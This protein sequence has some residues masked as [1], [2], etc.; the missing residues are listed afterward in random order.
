VKLPIRDTAAVFEAFPELRQSLLAHFDQCPLATRFDLEG[1]PYTGGDAARGIVFHHFAAKYLGAIKEMREKKMPQ[2]E[3]L[4]VL[5]E[6]ESQVDV[7]DLEHVHVPMSEREVLRIAALKFCEHEL[8]WDR[9]VFIEKR[10]Y[11]KVR[12]V[13]SDGVMVERVITGKP[14]V[15]IADP[16]DGIIIPDWKTTRSP[17]PRPA[18]QVEGEQFRDDPL[19]PEGYF[20]QQT[21]GFLGFRNLPKV[22]RITLREFYPLA[23]ESRNATL[24]RYQLEHIERNV[25]LTAQEIDRALAGGHDSPLWV[26]QAGR[27]CRYCPRPM[28]CPID[29]DGRD[30]PLP[31]EPEEREMWAER[32]IVNDRRRD[33]LRLAIR[34]DVSENGPINVSSEKGEYQLKWRT[35]PSGERRFGLWP[36]DA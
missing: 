10:F 30:I 2:A 31:I 9:I 19:S 33:Y 29:R 32:F 26:A 28:D 7:P 35:Y 16:P 27:H 25:G 4:E 17:P 11:A 1:A 34:E 18:K 23:G 24:Y 5:Y 13:D 6:C 20:Q 3:A 21:Y 15:V 36:K 12:Y 14:D 8:S 22:E